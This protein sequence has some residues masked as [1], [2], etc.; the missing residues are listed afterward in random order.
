MHALTFIC[1]TILQIE[2][3][4]VKFESLD[5]IINVL[6]GCF[7]CKGVFTEII[8]IF[9]RSPE[10]LIHHGLSL[11]DAI[12]QFSKWLFMKKLD[13]KVSLI[14]NLLINDSSC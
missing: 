10:H 14:K 8:N 4:P 2:Q 12:C 5:D 3:V 11:Y 6:C 9:L 7:Y 1:N 13:S